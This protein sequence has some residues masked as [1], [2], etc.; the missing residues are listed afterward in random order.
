MS[1][2]SCICVTCLL[3][4]QPR[5]L[6][7]H[8]K[9]LLLLALALSATAVRDVLASSA[10]AIQDAVSSVRNAAAG[11]LQDWA[12]AIASRRSSGGGSRPGHHRAASLTSSRPVDAG[13]S[14]RRSPPGLVKQFYWCLS[15]AVLMRSREP[16]LVSI[17][18]MS[19]II[20][21]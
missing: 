19:S 17:S 5:V 16:L 11:Q 8:A 3:L 9:R 4:L 10:A 6:L 1:M 21:G 14:S 7:N 18:Q 13:A 2:L 20:L 12:A 15:R